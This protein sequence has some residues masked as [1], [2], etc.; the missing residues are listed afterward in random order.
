M[1]ERYFLYTAQTDDGPLCLDYKDFIVCAKD[2]TESAKKA[3]D[4]AYSNIS[5]IEDIKFIKELDEI[6]P[7]YKIIN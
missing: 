2:K 4:Y 6:N 1:T 7:S 5:G 3:S